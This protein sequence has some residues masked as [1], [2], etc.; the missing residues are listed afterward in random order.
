MFSLFTP[1]E[2]RY[3]ISNHNTCTGHMSFWRRG[4]PH[5]HLI[6]LSL[7]PCPLQGYS[8]HPIILL[9]V[10]GP[11]KGYPSPR[12]G[13]YPGHDRIGYLPP[14]LGQGGVSPIQDKMGYPT[15][16]TGQ[17]WVSL[18]HDGVPSGTGYAWTGY[19]TGSMSLLQW[20]FNLNN[21]CFF[22]SIEAN[23]APHLPGSLIIHLIRLESEL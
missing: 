7:V 8:S 13:Q 15:S 5:L 11:T 9:L 1:G 18:I 16:R 6:I 17:D 3:L 10:P 12:W 4:V 23:S 20:Y 22:N 14:I 19:G 2:G 21:Q